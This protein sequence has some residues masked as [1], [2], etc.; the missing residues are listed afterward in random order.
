MYSSHTA[1]I[2]EAA[3]LLRLLPRGVTCQRRVRSKLL[4]ALCAR[5]SKLLAACCT[6]LVFLMLWTLW[7]WRSESFHSKRCSEL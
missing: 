1:A 7:T 3:L 5:R 2:D 4:A 6:W